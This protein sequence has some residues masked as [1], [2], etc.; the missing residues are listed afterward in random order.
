MYAIFDTNIFVGAGFN[1]GSASAALIDAARTGGLTLVWD[2]ATWDET[3]RV[4][5]KIPPVSW[6][7]VADIFVPEHAW[8]G[9]TDL[10]VAGFVEDP[11]DRKF[12]ALSLAT[13]A[14]LVSSDSH[15]LVHRDRLLA[16]PPS[17]FLG[18]LHP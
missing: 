4:L 1:P 3:R 16:M 2:A 8:T 5:T 9:G 11:E 13:G 7:A 18:L 14:A 10:A 15:L 17:Q 6:D 12:A